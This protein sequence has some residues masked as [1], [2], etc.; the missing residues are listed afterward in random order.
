MLKASV[1]VK[2]IPKE[3]KNSTL[4]KTTQA[5]DNNTQQNQFSGSQTLKTDFIPLMQIPE[6]DYQDM[7][8]PQRAAKSNIKKDFF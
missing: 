7:Y 6:L 4:I 2:T 3:C 8:C 5:T 1:L